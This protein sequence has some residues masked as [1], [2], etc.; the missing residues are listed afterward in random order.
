MSETIILAIIAC[1]CIVVVA[2]IIAVGVLIYNT[3]ER[4]ERLASKGY[5]SM[6]ERGF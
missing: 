6:N 2:F 3:Y 4:V 1:S 5:Q